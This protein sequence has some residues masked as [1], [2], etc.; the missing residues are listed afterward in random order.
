[1]TDVSFVL[2]TS[3][4]AFFCQWLKGAACWSNLS[5]LARFKQT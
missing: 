1:M 5:T 3:A 2:R 4:G